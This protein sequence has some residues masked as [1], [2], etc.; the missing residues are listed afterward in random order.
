MKSQCPFVSLIAAQTVATQRQQ[1]LILTNVLSL[2]FADLR[3]GVQEVVSATVQH[4]LT[5]QRGVGGL[6]P[7]ALSGTLTLHTVIIAAWR[8]D[9]NTA[10]RVRITFTSL[11][12]F[13][14]NVEIQI[15]HIY[16]LLLFCNIPVLYYSM[17]VTSA[18]RLF[19]SH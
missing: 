12:I 19:V 6:A 3:G 14:G 17:V 11:Y 5:L 18:N 16:S 7:P 13:S 4:T 10:P 1:S 8:R 15:P 9:R 2:T